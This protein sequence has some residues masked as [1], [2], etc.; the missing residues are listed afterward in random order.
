MPDTPLTPAVIDKY[1]EDALERTGLPGLAA[2]VTR[3][4]RVVHAGGYGHESGGGPVTADTPMRVA[5]LSKSFTATAVLVLVEQGRLSLDR[6]VSE[7]LPGFAPGDSRGGS[8]TVRQLLNQTSGLTDSTVDIGRLGQA[9][10][11]EQYVSLLD[12]AS[13]ATDPGTRFKYCNVNYNVAARLVEV[14]SGQSF[15]DFLAERVFGPLGMAHSAVSAGRITPADGYNSVFGAWVSRPELSEF[16]DGSGSGG[17]ITTVADMGKWLIAHNGRGPRLLSQAGLDVTHTSSPVAEYAMGWSPE[18]MG[19]DP[20]MLVHS[21]NLFTYSAFQAIDP[22]SG[23]G[24]AVLANSAALHDD[25]YDIVKGLVALSRGE[26]PGEVGGRRQ[27]FELVLGLIAL[28]AIGLGML[29]ALRSRRWAWRHGGR[30]WWRVALRLL[31]LAVPVLV[32]AV[33][34]AI[35]SFISGG[36]TVTWSQLTYF[37]APLTITLFVVAAAGTATVALRLVRL[38][39][40][41]SAE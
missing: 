2:V 19:A 39:S 15:G 40:V 1:L 37:A 33:Y 31:P 3:G 13:L 32:F 29:G 26:A 11:L 14:A 30:A 6:P 38:R 5:S 28:G 4:D 10:S 18:P 36:R 25:T 41:R 22:V 12:T 7:Q 17:V 24:F 34:P 9:R 21:G 23:Y 16:L 8:V 20:A 35:I 27:I